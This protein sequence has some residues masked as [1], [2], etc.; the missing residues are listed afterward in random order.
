MVSCDLPFLVPFL[1][2][3]FNRGLTLT[4]KTDRELI[5]DT[6]QPLTKHSPS[7]TFGRSH[8][9]NV[10]LTFNTSRYSILDQSFNSVSC[11]QVFDSIANQI[12]FDLHRNLPKNAEIDKMSKAFKVFSDAKFDTADYTY[13]STFMSIPKN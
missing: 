1:I 8:G 5:G 3:I 4:K 7:P 2:S 6:L 12:I 13:I 11:R 10:F 9:S